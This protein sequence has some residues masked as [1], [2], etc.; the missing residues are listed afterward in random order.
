MGKS[1]ANVLDVLGTLKKKWDYRSPMTDWPRVGFWQRTY[2]L[3]SIDISSGKSA[4]ILVT[5]ARAYGLP[6]PGNEFAA[7]ERRI[8]DYVNREAL[9]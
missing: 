4:Y 3:Y 1:Y 9:C 6:A 5:W 8:R 7:V 2:S